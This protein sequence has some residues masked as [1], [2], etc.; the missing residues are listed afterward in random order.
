LTEEYLP[1]IY[2]C[3][4][5]EGGIDQVERSRAFEEGAAALAQAAVSRFSQGLDPTA[6]TIAAGRARTTARGV[7]CDSS[8]YSV[9]A[10]DA[11]SAPSVCTPRSN[12]L[13]CVGSTSK[14]DMAR[15]SGVQ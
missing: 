7:P 5:R 2:R 4:Y 14:R 8:I 6:G 15:R 12:W 10:W 13:N 1:L 11:I 3:E 9:R